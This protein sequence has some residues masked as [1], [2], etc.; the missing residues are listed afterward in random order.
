MNKSNKCLLFEK[1]MLSYY[2]TWG[3]FMMKVTNIKESLIEQ[4]SNKVCGNLYY[5]SQVYFTYK[6]NKKEGSILSEEQMASI[7]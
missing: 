2:V 4:K 5:A 6:Y 1:N 3:L 7:F